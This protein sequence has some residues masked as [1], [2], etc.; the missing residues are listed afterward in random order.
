MIKR[1]GRRVTSRAHK[2]LIGCWHSSCLRTH[3]SYMVQLSNRN[4]Y[5]EIIDRYTCQSLAREL[6]KLIWWITYILGYWSFYIF[7]N[8]KSCLPP[9]LLST[10]LFA[11]SPRTPART[12]P[13]ISWE[14]VRRGRETEGDW[15]RESDLKPLSALSAFLVTR[16][17]WGFSIKDFKLLTYIFI[18]RPPFS[19]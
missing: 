6:K 13:R 10:F 9:L 7:F 14:K 15:E 8:F 1:H 18:S 4:K 17:Q 3:R 5:I 11:L 16:I 19:I 12:L 2:D